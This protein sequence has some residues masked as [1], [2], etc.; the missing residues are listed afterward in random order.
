RRYPQ[1]RTALEYT[2][3]WQLLVSTVLSA[4]TTDDNVN[5]V[6][7]VLFVR[8]PTAADLAAANP[9]EVEKVVFSTGFYRQKTLS[10]IA[11]SRDLVDGYGGVVPA[12]IDALTRLRGVGRK[13]A[14]VVLAEAFGA[15][16]IAV[17]T[18]V[19]RVARRL[20]LTTALDPEKIEADLRAL[21]PRARWAGV[22]MR[23]IQFGREVCEARRP[24]CWECDLRDRCP[25]PDKI[26]APG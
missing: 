14:S 25:Y 3:P 26:L 19:R 7:P 1:V 23:F 13:T 18:H 4:Q 24:R 9:E 8:W 2:D 5:R 21:Y 12:D 10:I 17:D 15:P 6:T 16:A 22:S 11:L 20:G